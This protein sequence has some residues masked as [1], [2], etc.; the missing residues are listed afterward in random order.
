MRFG[1]F[2]T[3]CLAGMHGVGKKPKT[4]ADVEK[5]KV[6]RKEA[7]SVIELNDNGTPVCPQHKILTVQKDG[8]W[9]P[10][11]SC[12]KVKECDYRISDQK[13]KKFQNQPTLV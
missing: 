9:G 12:P 3:F 1:N 2:W 13:V 10:Y 8:Y 7:R 5:K 4:K 11:W 6:K